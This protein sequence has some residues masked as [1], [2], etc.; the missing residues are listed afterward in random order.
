MMSIKSNIMKIGVCSVMV[1]VPLSQ[2]SLPSFAAEEIA[3]KESQDV[4][5]IPDPQLK[6]ELNLY[7]NQ[8]EN[9]DITEAQMA[10]FRNIT[11]NSGIKDLTGIEYLKN[12]T[13]LSINNINASYE[14]IQTLSSLEKLVIN[15]ENVNADIIPDLSVLSNLTFLDLSRT[16]I[17]DTIFSKISNIP[18][19]NKLDISNNKG[20]TKISE[21]NNL[22]SLQ[23]LR[24]SDCQITNFKGI[25]KFPN[26]TA[27]YGDGQLFGIDSFETDGFKNIKSSELT[28]DANAKTLFVPFSIVTVNT[29]LNYDGL[30][31][32]YN[33]N[34]DY[35]S[36]ALGDQ[37]YVVTNDKISIN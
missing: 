25:E 30:S 12:I 32:P 3:L 18:N 22:P 36:I 8:A 34:P 28:F 13:T 24:V 14:P 26:L 19:L 15:G 4:V 31:L 6:K 20:I 27:F 1:L 5:N 7:L 21:L 11:L 17:D 10:T 33:T 2:T 16:N 29:I 9:A 35:T 37:S 23:E